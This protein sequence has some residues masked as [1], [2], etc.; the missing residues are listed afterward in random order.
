[1]I[2]ESTSQPGP[3]AINIPPLAK[4]FAMLSP[5]ERKVA[6]A[7]QEG[8]GDL[9]V[10]AELGLAPGTV[11][12]RLASMKITFDVEK[13]G[14]LRDF[15]RSEAFA[16]ARK[17]VRIADFINVL[18]PDELRV[19]QAIKIQFPDLAAKDGEYFDENAAQEGLGMRTE[20]LTSIL[21]KLARRMGVSRQGLYRLAAHAEFPA[22]ETPGP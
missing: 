12:G 15:F 2:P 1:M 21:A 8:K 17:P 3:A 7:F 20:S 14:A 22:P 10:A 18:S 19:L 5:G 16:E 11:Q 9:E 13:P 4:Q 6:M